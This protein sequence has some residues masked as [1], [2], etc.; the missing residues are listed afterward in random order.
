MHEALSL[1][2]KLQIPPTMDVVVGGGGGKSVVLME[3]PTTAL[4]AVSRKV[5]TSNKSVPGD[6]VDGL[7][8]EL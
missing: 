4:E 1:N 6:S 7:K 5:R 3:H 2:R 8:Q